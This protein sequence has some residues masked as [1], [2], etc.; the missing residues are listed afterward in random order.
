MDVR[1]AEE[2]D[3]E[4]L[5]RLRSRLWPDTD[6]EIHRKEM[7]EMSTRPDRWETFVHAGSDGRLL[8][9]VEVSLRED[10]ASIRRN[11]IGYLEGWFVEPNHRRQGIGRQL[12]AAAEEWVRQHGCATMASDAAIDNKESHRAHAALGF[13]ESDRE[14]QFR[15]ILD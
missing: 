9:F 3:R 13:L 6:P 7:R 11:L 15:K 10:A 14:V 1:R 4:N 2:R 5:L 8:G 12:V